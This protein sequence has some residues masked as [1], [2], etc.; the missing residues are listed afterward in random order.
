MKR[1]NK[2]LDQNYTDSLVKKNVQGTVV[3]KE[4]YADGILGPMTIDSHEKKGTTVNRTFY[5]QLP[6][7]KSPYL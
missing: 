7:Q 4:G 3:S 1:Q 5:C 6:K 2:K